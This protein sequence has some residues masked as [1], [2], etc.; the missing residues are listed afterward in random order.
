MSQNRARVTGG[1]V[2]A[3]AMARPIV[4]STGTAARQPR[5]RIQALENLEPRTLLGAH[6][7]GDL[8]PGPFPSELNL[9]PVTI[10]DIGYFVASGPYG[11]ELWRTDGTLRGTYIV[12]DIMPGP[13]GGVIPWL[14]AYKDAVWFAA[15]DDSSGNAELWRSD[16]SGAGTAMFKDLSPA[17]GS[18]PRRFVESNGIM[19][20]QTV[21]TT[22][23]SQRE[24]W[25]CDGTVEG[26]TRVASI[27]GQTTWSML[28]A[29]GKVF[30]WGSTV[31]T[32]IYPNQLWVTDGTTAGT[33]LLLNGS[34]SFGPQEMLADG[35]EHN[36]YLYFDGGQTLIRTDGTTQGTAW[37]TSI[38]PT[39]ANVTR[40]L[41]VFDGRIYMTVN[42]STFSE[43]WSTDGTATGTRILKD[44]NPTG[45]SVVESMAVFNGRI[46]FR[47]DDGTSGYELWTSDGTAAGT[48]QLLDLN[49]GSF[50]GAGLVSQRNVLDNTVYFAGD[51][52]ISGWELWATDGTSAGT[53]LVQDIAP[54]ASSS[55]PWSFQPVGTL[56]FF[57]ASLP[58]TGSEPYVVDP[59]AR[60]F[61]DGIL[62]ISGDELPDTIQLTSSGS[63]L[64]VKLNARAFVFD[65][66]D[67]ANID[68]FGSGGADLI[69]IDD[70]IEGIAITVRGG[71]GDD[72]I[73]VG[74]PSGI[75]DPV[76]G[77]I[78]IEGG[79]GHDV[80]FFDDR[81][82]T[83]AAK[84]HIGPSSFNIG[85]GSAFLLSTLEKMT[86]LC[87][88]GADA[89]SVNPSPSMAI[90]V[91][92]SGGSDSIKLDGSGAEENGSTSS[93]GTTEYRYKNRQ[94]IFASSIEGVAR[95]DGAYVVSATFD[96]SGA[97]PQ[98]IYTFDGDAPL[99]SSSPLLLLNIDSGV[100]VTPQPGVYDAA[101][102]TLRIPVP[103]QLL[104]NGA[105][106]AILRAG[107]TG[108]STKTTTVSHLLSTYFLGGDFNRDRRVDIADLGLVATNWQKT[109]LGFSAGDANYDS[110]VDITD[111]GIVASNWQRTI[112]PLEPFDASL[113]PITVSPAISVAPSTAAPK[114]L[115]SRAV[116]RIGPALLSGD[117]DAVLV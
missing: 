71:S 110:V 48:R 100:V 27:G 54:N 70:A 111:L 66:N 97:T 65:R 85:D 57:Q 67:F 73:N 112:V 14:F 20:F 4:S 89:I 40:V 46:V 98:F 15:S 13:M 34:G 103:V 96:L 101:T 94:S 23:G 9:P 72:R 21:G 22:P 76:Q 55:S 39:N 75:I 91:D 42:S 32:S 107:S 113:R 93:Y 26:T 116:D 86:L 77:A 43:I 62:R 104:G 12:K 31:P 102:R 106:C 117:E 83:S 52:G 11:T 84:Y 6:I 108:T 51:N 49:P 17:A 25:R 109:P 18:F 1:V 29:L 68:V 74:T 114:R 79:A 81:G 95:Y 35:V 45:S 38:L 58:E 2:H 59:P 60:I 87:G 50:N 3:P 69:E 16:G 80:A 44:I 37:L 10:G 61:S 47:A 19:Y 8:Q 92:G 90:A 7:L 88:S 53:R 64:S 28:P 41:G 5:R 115:P 63:S 78:L 82:R 33:K 24:I 36:G 56:M 105:Y 30:F 99:A